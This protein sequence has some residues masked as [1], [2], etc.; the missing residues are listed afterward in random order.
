MKRFWI[1]VALSLLL[2]R[3]A[4]D[5]SADEPKKPGPGR[6]KG[7]ELRLVAKQAVYTN[8]QDKKL[9]EG[10]K[11]GEYPPALPVDLVL[12]VHNTRKEE[13][14]LRLNGDAQRLDLSLKGPGAVSVEAFNIFTQEYRFGKVVKVAAGKSHATPIKELA[15]GKRGGS[16]RAY[17]TEAGA[18][19]LGASLRT[20]VG[21]LD[22]K[23]EIVKLKPCVL[24][25]EPIKL[26]VKEADKK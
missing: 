14:H 3:A 4:L 2:G 1:I 8:I 6:P 9:L 25:A 16:H 5:I 22:E 15:Y 10:R 24:S 26:T 12:E 19:T 20:E 18:Y 17:W 23:D 11:P 7:V 21:W 13:M